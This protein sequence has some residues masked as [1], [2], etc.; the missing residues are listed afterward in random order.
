MIFFTKKETEKI[1]SVARPEVNATVWHVVSDSVGN[2]L[3][4]EEVGENGKLEQPIAILVEITGFRKGMAF[5]HRQ[6]LFVDL[7]V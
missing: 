6:T 3:E 1:D 5:H 4:K 7:I 2:F